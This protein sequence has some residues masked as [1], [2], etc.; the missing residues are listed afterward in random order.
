ML[1]FCFNISVRGSTSVTLSKLCSL[2]HVQPF[3]FYAAS[4]VSDVATLANFVVFTWNFHLG[5]IWNK[6]IAYAVV[7]VPN[8]QNSL[9]PF[10]LSQSLSD[11]HV[12]IKYAI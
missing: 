8:I 11:T 5:C 12:A 4:Q 9:L 6:V 2:V 3:G 7:L 10:A 1:F